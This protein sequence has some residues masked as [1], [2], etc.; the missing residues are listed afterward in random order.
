MQLMLEFRRFG[1]KI[2]FANY[3]KVRILHVSYTLP[4]QFTYLFIYSFFF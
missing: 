1:A 2:I 3:N 4:K